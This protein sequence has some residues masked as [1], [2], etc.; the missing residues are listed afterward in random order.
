MQLKSKLAR[1]VR[2]A[3]IIISS[4]PANAARLNEIARSHW[5]IENQL[6][7][8]L[9][10]VFNEDK[11]CIKNDN[12]SQN[13]DILRKWALNITANAKEK[14]SQ[15]LK[16]VMRKIPCLLIIFS[17]MSRNFFMRRL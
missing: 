15:S 8:R 11:A 17:T 2:I 10:V 5:S 12:S 6:H 1:K 7:W 3:G 16:S 9:D 14:P 4:L 13:I